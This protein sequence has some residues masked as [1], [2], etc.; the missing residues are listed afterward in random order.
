MQ[1]PRLLKLTASAVNLPIRISRAGLV[2][3]IF[4]ITFQQLANNDRIPIQ[5]HL[6]RIARVRRIPF[7]KVGESMAFYRLDDGVFIPF[8]I[9]I[10]FYLGKSEIPRWKRGFSRLCDGWRWSNH[11]VSSSR[12]FFS[13]RMKISTEGDFFIRVILPVEKTIGIF[14]LCRSTKSPP[15]PP[16]FNVAR[17]KLFITVALSI[18]PPRR[19]FINFPPDPWLLRHCTNVPSKA[20]CIVLY[21]S[22]FLFV[23]FGLMKAPRHGGIVPFGFRVMQ[24]CNGPRC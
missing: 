10:E 5:T 7:R 19:I 23:L 22:L 21:E 24:P 2:P 4:L 6:R 17:F 14:S 13:P 18:P 16:F 11:S 12:L 15:S 3:A 1:K 20:V 8:T 9:E